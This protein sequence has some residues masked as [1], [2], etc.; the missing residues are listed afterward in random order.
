MQAPQSSP[1]NAALIHTYRDQILDVAAVRYPEYARR[2]V[3]M[4]T[5]HDAQAVAVKQT[6]LVMYQETY[7]HRPARIIFAPTTHPDAAVALRDLLFE[8][9]RD[10]ET[11][12][13]AFVEQAQRAGALFASVTPHDHPSIPHRPCPNT[14]NDQPKL[15]PMH[16]PAASMLSASDDSSSCTDS[17]CTD[18]S[19]TTSI[20]SSNS[21]LELWEGLA[22]AYAAIGCQTRR[23]LTSAALGQ[24]MIDVR[25][26]QNPDY[27][28]DYPAFVDLYIGLRTTTATAAADAFQPVDLRGSYQ[29]VYPRSDS[30][31]GELMFRISYRMYGVLCGAAPLRSPAYVLLPVELDGERLRPCCVYDRWE[32]GVL[33]FR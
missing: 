14:N 2:H 3:V 5:T 25:V 30:R 21:Q 15:F 4:Y 23:R 29:Q 22:P 31:S 33:P 27:Y 1:T 20:N 18:S 13:G 17:S 28:A 10:L 19:C 9:S 11:Y 12:L 16:S 32:D 26:W 7:H 6:A 24:V 8:V